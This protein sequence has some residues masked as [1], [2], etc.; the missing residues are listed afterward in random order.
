M[1]NPLCEVTNN[2]VGSDTWMKGHPCPCKMC[3]AY[4]QGVKDAEESARVRMMTPV[5][6]PPF[7]LCDD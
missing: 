7:V 2:L 5:I 1:N 4:L 6:E 3:Q